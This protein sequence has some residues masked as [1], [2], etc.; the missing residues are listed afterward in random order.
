M[1]HQ[2]SGPPA[3]TV[4]QEAIRKHQAETKKGGDNGA[5]PQA[6]TT[7]DT[8]FHVL[9]SAS[10]GISNGV[11]TDAMIANQMQG[12][13]GRLDACLAVHVLCMLCSALPCMALYRGQTPSLGPRC[14][15]QVPLPQLHQW[16]YSGGPPSIHPS[17]WHASS[18]PSWHV[19]SAQQCL[20]FKWL[21]VQARSHH[22]VCYAPCTDLHVSDRHEHVFFVRGSTTRVGVRK[23]HHAR[24]GLR[25]MSQPP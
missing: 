19:P 9:S 17:D 22:Q 20:C 16:C 3:L 8:Y 1:P 18:I 4:F 7:I 14:T 24:A 23:I 5:T 13:G 25:L 12:T 21:P 11:V 2:S 10:T 15:L 6:T